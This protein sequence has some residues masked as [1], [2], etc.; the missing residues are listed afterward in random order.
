MEMSKQANNFVKTLKEIVGKERVIE[1]YGNIEELIQIVEHD[2]MC[3]SQYSYA[4]WGL[5]LLS[6]LYCLYHLK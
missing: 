2:G 6:V 1:K 4:Y 3:F 5:S